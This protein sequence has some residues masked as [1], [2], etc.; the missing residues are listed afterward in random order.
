[1]DMSTEQ[2]NHKPEQTPRTPAPGRH[3]GGAVR[4]GV[5]RVVLY[6]L[7]VT[8]PL[9]LAAA[10][11][12]RTDHGLVLEVAR[13]FGLVVFAILV[14]QFVLSAR[15]KWI[16]WPFGLDNLFLFHRAMAVFAA[17]LL[18]SHPLLMMWAERRWTLL[19]SSDVP[20]AIHLGRLA[21]LLLLVNVVVSLVRGALRWNFET[22][23]KAHN[24]VVVSLLLL[25]Y[26]HSVA[27]GGDLVSWPMRLL[28]AG[29][30][31]AALLAYGWHKF[32][33]PRLA[34]NAPYEVVDVRRETHNVW[35]IELR[36]PRTQP[37]GAE[38]Y[39]PGQ[40]HSITFYRSA[41]LPVEE[42][43]WTISSS[44]TAPGGRTSTIKESGDFTKTIGQTRPGDRAA[45][46]GAYGRF[47][48]LLHPRETD[49]VFVAGGI[50]ITPLMSMLRHMR[51]TRHEGSVLLLFANRSEADIVF[52]RQ[53]DEI[54]AGGHPRLRVVHIL[55][56]APDGW[57]GERGRID[58]QMLARH[59]GPG[60]A[61]AG[62]GYYVCGPRGMSNDVM[63]ALRA[64]G[65]RA[66][67][68][69]YERFAL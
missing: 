49:F 47:S 58:A 31:G 64:L 68:I 44:P 55:N 69:H 52:R 61:A 50:G 8:A 21:L 19:T 60:A 45:I 46:R 59:C 7:V 3:A 38:D 13:S 22:W 54:A 43:H 63:A 36:P 28:W 33:A 41:D 17:L 30:L 35:T 9:L 67:Q 1:M 65:V 57:H 29:L 62:K 53:L 39:L 10:L 37:R 14:L 16:E 26:V 5:L 15:F 42:H 18:L 34:R 6:L 20:P 23:R 48:Y 51:D 11:Q 66:R 12:P 4:S 32:V 25:S 40:F 27:L 24:V 2:N 56:Q